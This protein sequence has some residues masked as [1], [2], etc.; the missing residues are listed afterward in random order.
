MTE[1]NPRLQPSNRQDM[2]LDKLGSQ[3][4][5]LLDAPYPS[6]DVR[7]YTDA[8]VD[9]DHLVDTLLRA[10]FRWLLC[11]YIH[12]ALHRLGNP[13]WSKEIRFLYF[14]DR[15]ERKFGEERRIECLWRNYSNHES[16]RHHVVVPETL[17]TKIRIQDRAASLSFPDLDS[18]IDA[19]L[20]TVARDFS[21]LV[22]YMLEMHRR[23]SAP[24]KRSDLRRGA[25]PSLT[26]TQWINSKRSKL[27]RSLRTIQLL[28]R[29]KT[30]ASRGR[31]ALAEARGRMRDQSDLAVPDGPVE[32]ASEMA[33][34]V[35]EMRHAGQKSGLKQKLEL[36]AETFLRV[37]G[38]RRFEVDESAAIQSIG[39]HITNIV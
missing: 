25:P 13:F 28:L 37:T 32:I 38:L 17:R 20:Q 11:G 23:L 22:P 39:G 1:T 30:E 3:D 21:A 9:Y 34:L 16:S 29:G 2:G 36:L 6:T 14:S 19:G 10:K 4:T 33:H 27:G 35:L 15:E 31:Q 5:V 26:C 12:P 18:K 24:G 7:S 8:T